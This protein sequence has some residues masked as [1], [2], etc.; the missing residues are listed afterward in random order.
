MNN[1]FPT[2]LQHLHGLTSEDPDTFMF[3]FFLFFY[4]TYYCA[5]DEQKLNLFPSTLKD[6]ALRQF[7]G[8]PRGSITTWAQMKHTFNIKYRDYYKSKETKQEIFR[9]TLV[10]NESLEEYEERFQL[11]YRRANC[12]L[13]LESLKLILI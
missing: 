3:D 11:N 2:S 5:F 10:P 6:A 1:I 9:M 12:T 4:R 8:L 7:M 13:D